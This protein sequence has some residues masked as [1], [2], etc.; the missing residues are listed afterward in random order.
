MA[1]LN[2]NCASLQYDEYLFKV[3]NV[4]KKLFSFTEAMKESELFC[5]KLMS[6]LHSCLDVVVAIWKMAFVRSLSYCCS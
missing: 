3:L 6:H 2:D 5:F 4:Q 1:V